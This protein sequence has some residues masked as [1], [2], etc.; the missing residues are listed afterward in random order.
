[1]RVV[2]HDGLARAH[3]AE[4]ADPP[5]LAYAH[6]DRQR[7]R[8]LRARR[9]HHRLRRG[10]AARIR[11]RRDHRLGPRACSSAATWP[12]SSSDCGDF[13]ARR[14]AWPNA[15]AWRRSPATTAHARATPPA[16]P[17][18]WRCSTPT[19]ST[20][21]AAAL[22]RDRAC[23]RRIC[24]SRKSRVRYSGAIT[25]ADGFKAQLAACKMRFY[26]FRQLKVKVGIDGQDDVDR[27][28]RF[29]AASAQRWTCASTPTKRGRRATSSQRIVELKPFGISVGRA[30]G[31][32][33]RRRRAWPQVRGRDGAPIML[34]ESLCGMVDAERAVANGTCDLFNLRL[35][36]CGGF[37]PTLRLA[38]F[39]T[40]A[41]PRLSARL[42]GR[43]DGD[44]VGGGPALRR[45]RGGLALP[46][47]LVRPPPGEG[48]ARA[49]TTSRSAGAAGRRRWRGRA[50]ASTSIRRPWS[51]S[52]CARRCCLADA[53]A[54]TVE[55]FT[56]S[57]GYVWRYRRYP[58]AGAA[59]AEV[60]F[61]HGIQ[62]H[63]GWY[64]GSCTQ[65]AQAGF[66][67]SFLDRRGS[68]LNAR[69]TRRRARLSPPARRPRGVPDRA[70]AGRHARAARSPRCRCSWRA[71]RG[72]ASSPSPWNAA[73]RAWSTA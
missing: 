9:R 55:T 36:K 70:A 33:R 54:F 4:E 15:C 21:G 62:S 7:R 12:R 5:R 25:S 1:M 27:L 3:P 72:A 26:G 63:G 42:P 57:D 40:A 24:T 47:R 39:A 23:W 44:P 56:A 73:T 61:I 16:A 71:S 59:R 68:G 52:A 50:W 8:P 60:V 43:R 45:Q 18:S 30:A 22:R 32:A 34:D 48:S 67:V 11:H 28:R 38:Q 51:A 41:R 6:R 14:R 66:N 49:T 46:G 37:I 19:A 13:A 53:A 64:E 2:E 20:F 31:A 58:A 69:G 17:S 35:S 65:L 29:A 10:R